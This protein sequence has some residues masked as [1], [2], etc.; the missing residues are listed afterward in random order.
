MLESIIN[1]M[2]DEK[3]QV[4]QALFVEPSGGWKAFTQ[5]RAE[6]QK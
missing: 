6:G 2:R 1:K 5:A 4:L 3:T